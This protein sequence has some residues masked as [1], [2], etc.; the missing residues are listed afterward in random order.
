[1]VAA[2]LWERGMAVER[3][4]AGRSAIAWRLTLERVLVRLGLAEPTGRTVGDVAA[5]RSL[6]RLARV[7]KRLRSLRAAGA[8]ERRQGR[9]AVRL[10]RAVE[11]AVEHAGLACDPARQQEL[12]AHL[13]VL[14][15]AGRLADLDPRSPWTD[16][17]GGSSSVRSARTPAAVAVRPAAAHTDRT[18]S[19]VRTERTRVVNELAEAIRADPDG[20]RP[21][22][23]D[24]MARTGYGRSWCEKRVA[25]ARALAC[26]PAA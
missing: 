23:A 19:P 15:H 12:L 13:G 11:R 22:Y 24:L 9:A 3:R 21:D 18:P 1:M 20:W 10:D 4:R 5:G 14:Y 26:R 16:G 8:S 2:W 7:A 6:A 17:D 25:E